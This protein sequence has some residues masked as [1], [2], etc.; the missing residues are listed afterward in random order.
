MGSKSAIVPFV[1][2]SSC[3]LKILALMV[4]T[5]DSEL[6]TIL[7]G[8]FDLTHL[9]IE[10]DYNSPTLG[11]IALFNALASDL[12]PTLTSLAFGFGRTFAKR[13]VF[14]SMARLRFRRQLPHPRLTQLRLFGGWQN[15]IKLCPPHTAVEIQKMCK[16]GFDV[17]FLGPREAN[18]LKGQDFFLDFN[19][20]CRMCY[21]LDA[22]RGKAII[23]SQ[24]F[25][26]SAIGQL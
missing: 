18:V 19:I 1:Q 10:E 6:I 14:F 5:V 12:C 16:E 4:C 8:L 25:G 7:R 17:A 2:R 13:D 23:G 3:L 22:I 20:S 21:H 26:K 15:R 9:V 24:T 11:Q